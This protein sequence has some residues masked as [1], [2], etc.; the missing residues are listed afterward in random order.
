MAYF[1][2]GTEGMVFDEECSNCRLGTEQCP[3]AF[4]QQM[5]NYDAC[6]NEVATTILNCLVKQGDNFEYLGCQMKPLI[7]KL[8][9]M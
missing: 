6:N 2:N 9:V 5:F 4:V 1:S 8:L 3:I 7:D